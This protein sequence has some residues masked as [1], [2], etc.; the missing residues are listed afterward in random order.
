M[1]TATTR[2]RLCQ[3]IGCDEPHRAKGRCTRHYAQW[4]RGHRAAL[5]LP[6]P[7]YGDVAVKAK[8]P[9]PA[10]SAPSPLPA[11]PPYGWGHLPLHWDVGVEQPVGPYFD[12]ARVVWG[13]PT[14]T[15]EVVLRD[16]R[17]PWFEVGLRA[18]WVALSGGV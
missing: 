16:D 1:S 5:L 4:M 2:R 12:Y 13:A 7:R 18:P 15:A 3:V 17:L 14:I 8:K 11:G 6:D 9:A 10:P